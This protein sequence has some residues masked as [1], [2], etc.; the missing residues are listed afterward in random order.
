[1]HGEE[2]QPPIPW[3][4]GRLRPRPNLA[5]VPRPPPRP[6]PPKNNS[7]THV[8]V[9]GGHRQPPAGGGGRGRAQGGRGGGGGAEGEHIGG[10]VRAVKERRATEKQPYVGSR[11]Y[12]FSSHSSFIFAP[13]VHA[14]AF[15]CMLPRPLTRVPLTTEDR[16]DVRV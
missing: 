6:A 9:V 4:R 7:S 1:M 5:L 8:F 15:S 11:R 12:L 10:R 3:A 16:E 2:D 14:F 13:R